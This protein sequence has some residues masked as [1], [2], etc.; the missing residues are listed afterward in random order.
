MLTL[1]TLNIR[2]ARDK[3]HYINNIIN[4]QKI[5]ILLL[6]ETNIGTIEEANKLDAY[7]G[8]KNSL[9]STG[10][11]CRGTSILCTSEKHKIK[12]TYTD[13]QGRIACITLNI[14]KTEITII[15][16]YAPT[17]R[18]EQKHF[19]HTLNELINTEY[20]NKTILLAG[21]FNMVID[22][23]D[24]I[25]QDDRKMKRLKHD[26][27]QIN[28]LNNIIKTT[29]LQDTYKKT[30]L[31][32]TETTHYSR[33]HHSA[34]RLDRIYAH[35]SITVNKVKHLAQTLTFTDHKIVIA[36]LQI[37]PTH[38]TKNTYW[39]LNNTLLENS[40][41]IA[42]IRKLASEFTQRASNT[43]ALEHW[44]DFKYTVR[45]YSIKIARQINIDRNIMEEML[46]RQLD[47][48]I[49]H[50]ASQDKIEK[51]ES[52]L[53]KIQTHRHKGALIRSRIDM[54]GNEEPSHYNT[55]LE[56]IHCNSKQICSITDD[57]GTITND[58]ESIKR[59]FTLYYQNLF[60]KGDTDYEIQEHYLN[61]ITRLDNEDCTK[62]NAPIT[63][64]EISKTIDGLKLNKAPG[65]D[66]LT[67]EFYKT[68]KNDLILLLHTTFQ[69]IHERED[70]ATDFNRAYI[71]L[72]PKH[73]TDRTKIINYRPIS[74]LNSDYKILT[75][76]LVKKLEPFIP[77][78]I[79]P[80]Q[81]YSIPG[82]NIQNHTHLIRDIIHYS[83]QKDTQLA[84][85]S[86]DQ[87]K[88]F[89]RVDHTWL[90]KTIDAYNLGHYFKTW[91]KIIYNNAH[92]HL[93][94]NNSVTS[95]FHIQKSVRQGCP[96][97][98]LLYILSLE[99]LLENIRQDNSIKGL[100]IPNTVGKKILA[101][102]DD[103]TFLVQT[104][105]A[106]QTVIEKFNNFGKGSGGK[107]NV[108]KS[109]VM[110][111]GKWKGKDNYNIDITITDK[112]RIYG[113]TYTSDPTKDDQETWAI[114]NN[115]INHNLEK[116]QYCNT[117]IFARA[118]LV[119]R[120]IIPKIIFVATNS[121]I[122]NSFIK[123]TNKHIREF[124]F[125]NTIRNISHKT[126]IQNKL[127]GGIGLHDIHTKI[128]TFRLKHLDRIR[129]EPHYHPLAQY[130]IG[131]NIKSILK[132]NITTPH[133]GGNDIGS[134]YK[135]TLATFQGNKSIIG[136]DTKKIYDILIKQQATLLYTRISWAREHNIIDIKD[137]FRNLH[138]K[139]ITP[140][141]REVAYRLIFNTT[142]VSRNTKSNQNVK[143]TCQTCKQNIQETEKHIYLDCTLIQKAKQT[144]A[145]IL[146]TT[147]QTATTNKAITLN[148]INTTRQR[149]EDV[150]RLVATAI[151]R[152]TIWEHRNKIRFFLK[153][154][155]DIE[156]KEVF[157]ARLRHRLGALT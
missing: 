157:Q 107:I 37:N 81:Q 120:Y 31:S 70:C 98:P 87:Q 92:S 151:Y 68:F 22:D 52:E 109:K 34:A 149:A 121:T 103:T 1:A 119:N 97:S 89:D 153:K 66:G 152:S 62:I 3:T 51:V 135:E 44:E 16:V 114:L 23:T 35:E 63:K 123:Q 53:N 130:Y 9:H 94:I 13:K 105:K 2:G 11:N 139:R 76:T 39:K 28:T 108:E 83:T 67:S 43:H 78:L 58:L 46:D 80:D 118:A 27:E 15:N 144:L 102:A 29:S 106:I 30:H 84:I 25:G 99:P 104:E 85:L 6:Q 143:I 8:I 131:L 79:H 90:M 115:K 45:E 127:N 40:E 146:K 125:K 134:F 61:Y 64:E 77:K 12:S 132:L 88:A 124:I 72:I 128:N 156:L 4:K 154:C 32:F 111:I 150:N 101:Y 148:L 86:I 110:G 155:S 56:K 50:N 60:N 55:I 91:I 26:K 69:D 75:K 138:N 140:K 57:N 113:I 129:I 65:P 126:L 49:S 24:L 10:F 41:Y 59:H 142:P 145:K 21:D 19:Y 14:D 95:A 42:E 7:I 38:R 147:N 18:Q 122:P 116:Y 73:D 36:Q 96:L 137:T 20:K 47:T 141:E 136:E 71:T 5:D 74:L 54:I 93:L 117:T 33:T 112:L 82:R 100:Y 48:L 133:Y 17:H